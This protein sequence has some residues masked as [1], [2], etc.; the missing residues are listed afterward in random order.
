MAAVSLRRDPE[1][2]AIECEHVRVPCLLTCP[3][4]LSAFSPCDAVRRFG[5]QCCKTKPAGPRR[6]ERML[7]A[8]R[9]L[10]Y[11]AGP[12]LGIFALAATAYTS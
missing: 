3:W 8:P 6:E 10:F 7:L 12:A 4:T 5:V 1:E 11:S 9:T 2:V